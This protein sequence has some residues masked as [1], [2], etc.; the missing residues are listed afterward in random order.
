MNA[1]VAAAGG[2]L[3]PD[4][5]LVVLGTNKYGQCPVAGAKELALDVPTDAPPG[6][7][8]PEGAGG[9]TWRVARAAL[10]SGCTLLLG[11]DGRPYALGANSQGELGRGHDNR[12][13][14]DTR[15]P[16]LVPGTGGPVRRIVQVAAGASHC[17]AVT[18]GGQGGGSCSR[19][20]GT[21]A[22]SAA[23]AR[24]GATNAA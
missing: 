12:H 10:G 6:W 7:W 1:A 22:A 8:R 4:R 14:P 18:G 3:A 5:Q 21:G 23:R 20:A 11:A 19:G 2:V 9:G 13:D 16:R 17:A 15:V 24:R